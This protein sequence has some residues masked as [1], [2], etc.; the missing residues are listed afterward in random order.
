MQVVQLFLSGQIIVAQSI[1]YFT[2][3][4]FDFIRNIGT[5]QCCNHLICNV[6][7]TI[8]AGMDTLTVELKCTA[9]VIL[10]CQVFAGIIRFKVGFCI[11][12][13]NIGR[14][15]ILQCKCNVLQ[16]CAL[17][18]VG[19]SAAD[20]EDSLFAVDGGSD[21]PAINRVKHTHDNQLSIRI[22]FLDS[23][24]HLGIVVVVACV[25]VNEALCQ[26]TSQL[27]RIL[28]GL[29][30]CRNIL[31][32]QAQGIHNR[33]ENIQSFLEFLHGSIVFAN[34]DLA[35]IQVQS[36]LAVHD[37]VHLLTDK[38]QDVTTADSNGDQVSLLYS[39]D[40]LLLSFQNG[41]KGQ[42]IF[43]FLLVVVIFYNGNAQEIQQVFS[44]KCA[45]AVVAELIFPVVAKVMLCQQQVG[46][47]NNILA[48]AIL[49]VVGIAIKAVT[50]HG[51][52]AQGQVVGLLVRNILSCGSRNTQ[53]NQSVVQAS[54][55]CFSLSCLLLSTSL[56]ECSQLSTD[57]GFHSIQ[58]IGCQDR[59]IGHLE[60]LN[61][62]G[63]IVHIF[64]VVLAHHHGIQVGI[65][66][67]QNAHVQFQLSI[68]EIVSSGLFQS[69][70]NSCGNL[71][72]A[73][74][75]GMCEEGV[76]QLI[77][78][79][80]N[81]NCGKHGIIDD[82]RSNFTTNTGRLCNLSFAISKAMVNQFNLELC[83]GVVNETSKHATQHITGC[84]IEAIE[85]VSAY[86]HGVQQCN[87]LENSNHQ[88]VSIVQGVVVYLICSI[89]LVGKLSLRSRNNCID[90]LVKLSKAFSNVLIAVSSICKTIDN[91]SLVHGH[92]NNHFTV[93]LMTTSKIF[94]KLCKVFPACSS[95]V[96]VEFSSKVCSCCII[97]NCCFIVTGQNLVVTINRIVN[98]STK[99]SCN[100]TVDSSKNL[101][102]TVLDSNL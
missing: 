60:H 91:V 66:L 38:G 22:D 52:V 15:I 25:A 86:H 20:V 88:I 74:T 13:V 7:V 12:N 67:C 87:F 34:T 32:Q 14:C 48:P 3:D 5:T 1:V 72:A 59:I 53:L 62:D 50:D 61:D 71:I 26:S 11:R 40:E 42:L 55:G 54:C 70:H 77:T 19:N 101:T 41:S 58:V 23:L 82:L 99:V 93:C 44:T 92:F 47:A 33:N 46:R 95:I 89:E 78:N 39:S 73:L 100:S 10:K 75:I 79:C 24:Q 36:L 27:S 56:L 63:Q 69:A 102:E 65:L 84:C 30:F 81:S 18:Q 28:Q 97:S 37:A 49:L 8:F 96:R 2:H 45:L 76:T 85:A 43:N 83:H 57:L 29:H 80:Q 98:C 90:C 6:L 31:I 4:G 9:K 64:Q 16:I 68:G 94:L 51:A 21:S 35:P 17:H